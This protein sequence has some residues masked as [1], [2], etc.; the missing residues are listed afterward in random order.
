MGPEDEAGIVGL[1]I[2]SVVRL[3]EWYRV[4][5][6]GRGQCGDAAGV[7][8]SGDAAGVMQGGEWQC[9]E[10]AAVVQLGL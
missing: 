10:V 7:M 3:L 2:C 4:M 9:S 1:G 5:R 6:L 8:Q